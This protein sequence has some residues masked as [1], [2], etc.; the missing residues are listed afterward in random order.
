[1]L[2]LVMPALPA[3]A[4]PV[5]KTVDEEGKV[6]YT[7]TPPEPGETAFE[8]TIDAP[9]SRQRAEQA[10]Q[11]H[12]RNEEAARILEQNRKRRDQITAE[13]NRLKRARHVS[14][15]AAQVPAALAFPVQAAVWCV[16]LRHHPWRCRSH[17]GSAK[18]RIRLQ[19]SGDRRFAHTFQRDS[20]DHRDRR[21]LF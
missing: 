6:T 17:S 18:P 12:E 21:F 14:G 13:E 10:R 20:S 1:M 4:E 15:T 5:Y 3:Y 9:P 19:Q 8:I 2:L 11:R 16:W 7:Q